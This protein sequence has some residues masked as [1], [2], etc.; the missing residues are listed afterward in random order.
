MGGARSQPGCAAARVRAAD[1]GAAPPGSGAGREEGA[2][3]P[4]PR[5]ERGQPRAPGSGSGPAR[6][7][8]GHSLIRASRVSGSIAGSIRHGPPPR[9]RP[10][11]P[12]ALAGTPRHRPQPVKGAASARRSRNCTLGRWAPSRRR[13]ARP[14]RHLLANPSPWRLAI[15]PVGLAGGL[16][17]PCVQA[18]KEVESLGVA[19]GTIETPRDALTRVS[20]TQTPVTASG[21]T[22][23]GHFCQG[24]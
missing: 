3:G 10:P 15:S 13:R 2:R 20:V 22:L 7:P 6:A 12:A 21:T 5:R 4:R 14:E 1:W 9:H 16:A 11:P 24:L 17:A 18:G 19:G 23:R 8:P